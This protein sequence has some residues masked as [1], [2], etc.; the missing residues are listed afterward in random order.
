MAKKIDFDTT[1]PEKYASLAPQL[2]LFEFPV[3]DP[4][5]LSRRVA[6]RPKC[7]FLSGGNLS[8]LVVRNASFKVATTLKPCVAM[9]FGHE[10]LLI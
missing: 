10:N 9:S 3:V 7:P 1:R 5:R 8:A 4:P 2:R 6:N